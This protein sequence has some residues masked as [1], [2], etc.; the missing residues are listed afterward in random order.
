M[1]PLFIPRVFNTGGPNPLSEHRVAV[2]ST[3]PALQE[4]AVAKTEEADAQARPG[5]HLEMIF[6]LESLA[7]PGERMDLAERIYFFFFTDHPREL[8]IKAQHFFF[9]YRSSYVILGI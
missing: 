2:A 9:D 3:A 7:F 4:M 6:P 8:L 1:T 5:I